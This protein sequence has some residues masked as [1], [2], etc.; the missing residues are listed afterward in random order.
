[1]PRS[2]WTLNR[3]PGGL[4][5]FVIVQVAVWPSP[6]VTTPVAEQAPENDAE[7]VASLSSDTAYVPGASV[8]ARPASVPGCGLP[9]TSVD[10]ART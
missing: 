3:F 1:M 10:P 8:Y 7:Y 2:G 9:A 5:L 6:S 4:S